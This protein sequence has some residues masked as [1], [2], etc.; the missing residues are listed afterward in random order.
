MQG[1]GVSLQHIGAAEAS[2]NQQRRVSRRTTQKAGGLQPL[3]TQQLKGMPGQGG[4]RNS[5][6]QNLDSGGANAGANLVPV[7]S[8]QVYSNVS[9]V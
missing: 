7:R 5:A 2:F 9:S 4:N 1:Q 6:Q 8:R 3:P